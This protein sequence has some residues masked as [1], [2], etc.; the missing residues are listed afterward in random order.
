MLMYSYLQF[1]QIQT[2]LYRQTT[3]DLPIIPNDIP[4]KIFNL[5][6]KIIIITII[7]SKHILIPIPI[8][9]IMLIEKLK[10][11]YKTNSNTKHNSQVWMYMI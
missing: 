11:K 1:R 7:M 5:N 9:I 4:T 8:H 2:F 10:I 6:P 3:I